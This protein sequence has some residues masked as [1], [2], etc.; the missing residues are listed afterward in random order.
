MTL[1]RVSAI[2]AIVALGVALHYAITLFGAPGDTHLGAIAHVEQY[3]LWPASMLA[4]AVLPT[5]YVYIICEGEP[6]PHS[7]IILGTTLAFFNMFLW[8][9]TAALI[10][11]ALSRWRVSYGARI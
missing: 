5:R 7:G 11:L 8:S 2:A 3:M 9:A 1:L 6:P 10:Y 4:S